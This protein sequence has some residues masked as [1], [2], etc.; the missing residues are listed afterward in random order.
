MAP[1]KR[2]T[3]KFIFYFE[4]SLCDSDSWTSA[5]GFQG[6]VEA[7]IPFNCTVPLTAWAG[8]NVSMQGAGWEEDWGDWSSTR[9]F[10]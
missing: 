2:R 4:Y 8:F 5:F 9:R 1:I 10:T 6:G 3:E 7:H